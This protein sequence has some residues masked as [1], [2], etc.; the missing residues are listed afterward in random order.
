MNRN[1][2]TRISIVG[3]WFLSFIFWRIVRFL[4][5]QKV[6]MNCHANAT[7]NI[8]IACLP[9]HPQTSAHAPSTRSERQIAMPMKLRLRWILFASS[10]CAT[11]MQISRMSKIKFHWLKRNWY[12]PPPSFGIG[13]LTP[14]S[15]VKKATVIIK[16]LSSLSP[17]TH[18]LA[19]YFIT[20][21]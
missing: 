18:Y 7:A 15:E 9:P 17:Q 1:K 8:H 16:Q 19:K 12:P 3:R 10:V 21:Y 4:S 5:V 2:W 20:F 14:P 11:N 6:S 13:I